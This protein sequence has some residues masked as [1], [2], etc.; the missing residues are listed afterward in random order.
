MS[1]VQF[2]RSLWL[3]W[4]VVSTTGVCL[5]GS[6]LRAMCRSLVDP[7]ILVAL[8]ACMYCMRSCIGYSL[9]RPSGCFKMSSVHTEA[10][11]S[12]SFPQI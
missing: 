5:G 7:F 6:E 1:E 2:L 4:L 8:A 11:N 3:A 12:K 9:M 10:S